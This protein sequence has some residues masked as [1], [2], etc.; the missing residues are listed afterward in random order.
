MIGQER[1]DTTKV[2]FSSDDDEDTKMRGSPKEEVRSY[3]PQRALTPDHE[4]SPSLPTHAVDLN[5]KPCS[6]AQ[7]KHRHYIDKEPQSTKV[8]KPEAKE[9][10]TEKT[11][12]SKANKNKTKRQTYKG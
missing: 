1:C 8:N 3:G 5:K 11:T 10:T 6:S 12:Y 7:P 2:L 9:K 4:G